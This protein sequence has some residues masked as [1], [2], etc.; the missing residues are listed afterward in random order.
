MNSYDLKYLYYLKA[1]GY[2]YI[3]FN[4]LKTNYFGAK[5][6]NDFFYHLSKCNLCGNSKQCNY[7]F[8]SKQKNADV[9]VIFK[10]ISKDIDKENSIFFDKNILKLNQILKQNLPN[11]TIYFTF[12]IKCFGR[13]DFTCRDFI[14]EEIDILSP[15]VIL[16]IG[17]DV[18]KFVLQNNNLPQE[19]ILNG[20]IFKYKNSHVIT[21]ADIKYIITGLNFMGFINKIKYLL[22]LCN[23]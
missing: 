5:D 10:N 19:K 8:Y 23:K 9:M 2:E 16:T 11:H 6:I 4:V 3:D 1:F 20:S 13:D 14:F 18:G 22:K 17:E 15:S 12:L 7:R 21:S